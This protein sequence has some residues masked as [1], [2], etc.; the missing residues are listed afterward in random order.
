MLEIVEK[1]SLQQQFRLVEIAHETSDSVIRQHALTVLG[2]YLTP[3]QF[4]SLPSTAPLSNGDRD[5]G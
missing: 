2:T 4:A 3:L 1:L 5:H